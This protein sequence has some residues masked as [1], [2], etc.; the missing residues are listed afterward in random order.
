MARMKQV[1]K[2]NQGKPVKSGRVATK[3]G[4]AP[5]ATGG[6]KKPHRYRPGTVALR[7]IRRYQKSYELLLRKQPFQ[8]LVR[9]IGQKC[10]E[11]LR[12][13]SSAIV[14]L[15]NAAEEHLVRL[16]GDSNNAVIHANRVTL[17][18]SD[19]VLARKLRGE[20]PV[21]SSDKAP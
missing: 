3:A 7:E 17:M 12:F 18:K 20:P 11:D 6:V 21:P 9:E 2:K 14:A 10:K 1:A 16:F 8:R 4:T 19:M 13:Q 5:V 15:Q